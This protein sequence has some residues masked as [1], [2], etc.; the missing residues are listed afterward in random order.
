MKKYL[1]LNFEPERL[2]NEQKKDDFDAIMDLIDNVYREYQNYEKLAK[3][4]YDVSNG[5]DNLLEMNQCLGQEELIKVYEKKYK[6]MYNLTVLYSQVEK[7]NFINLT[8]QTNN[9]FASE[10]NKKQIVRGYELTRARLNYLQK[11][12]RVDNIQTDEG[13]MNLIFSQKLYNLIVK[14]SFVIHLE[15]NVAYKLLQNV[16]L[17]FINCR[18]DANFINK[19]S[20]QIEHPFDYDLAIHMI[21]C[22]TAYQSEFIPLS[23]VYYV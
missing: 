8:Y 1:K 23:L 2:T 6:Y 3:V 12:D 9:H 4:Y 21:K 7:S 5:I 16:T 10:I 15:K 20:A 17:L 14:N 18:L 11:Y 13:F 22:L 19:I